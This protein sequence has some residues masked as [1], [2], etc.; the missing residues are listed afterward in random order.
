MD[1]VVICTAHSLFSIS[2]RAV[3]GDLVDHRDDRHDGNLGLRLICA[4]ACPASFVG[5]P[6]AHGRKLANGLEW[7]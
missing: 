4:A 2:K 3:F 5:A 7:N 6:K 1:I